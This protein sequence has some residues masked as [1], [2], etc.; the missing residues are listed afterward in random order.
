M[1]CS[2]AFFKRDE[3]LKKYMTLGKIFEF[4]TKP[5]Q[6]GL[7]SL[8]RLNFM[9]AQIWYLQIMYIQYTTVTKIYSYVHKS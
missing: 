9:I 8:I 4:A 3:I 2:T 1:F 6:L 5:E 7:S